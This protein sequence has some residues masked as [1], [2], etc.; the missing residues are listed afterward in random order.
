MYFNVHCTAILVEVCNVECFEPVDD[1]KDAK[2]EKLVPQVH[3]E[4]KGLLQ[5]PATHN[6]TL[7]QQL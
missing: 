7:E 5:T 1:G 4:L 3:A 2:H 6:Y